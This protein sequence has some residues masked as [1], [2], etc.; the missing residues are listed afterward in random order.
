[1]ELLITRRLTPKKDIPGTD[2]KHLCTDLIPWIA[3][4]ILLRPRSPTMQG[5]R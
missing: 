4:N 2:L 3:S 5:F 1:M